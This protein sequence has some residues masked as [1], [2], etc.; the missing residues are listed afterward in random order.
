MIECLR[1]LDIAV[2][3]CE[4]NGDRIDYQL[5]Q[6]NAK[7]IDSIRGT[8]QALRQPKGKGNTIYSVHIP[9]DIT[10]LYYDDSIPL[11]ATA[12]H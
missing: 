6:I 4:I 1:N 9:A 8:I 5:M 11:V 10:E 3:G 2:I 7:H 12:H